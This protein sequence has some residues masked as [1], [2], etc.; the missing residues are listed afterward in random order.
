MRAV[1]VG[2]DLRPAVASRRPEQSVDDRVSGDEYV[3]LA[4]AL[5]QEVRPCALGG[6]K[7]PPGESG[8]DDPVRL[9]RKR[10]PE[11]SGSK[12]RLH[13]PDRDPA[14]E[15][16]KGRAHDGGGVALHEHR[17]GPFRLQCLVE[18]EQ[19]PARQADEGLAVAHDVEIAIRPDIEMTKRLVKQPTVL[20]GRKN[21]ELGPMFVRER[22]HHRDHLDDLGTRSHQTEDSSA[23]ADPVFGKGGAQSRFSGRDLRY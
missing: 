5:S 1:R 7:V 12:P 13:M 2:L 22:R 3:L 4:N 17:T 23:H 11:V 19:Q 16:G 8:H 9:L 10:I 14:I 18:A 6:R 15:A 20:S 21:P